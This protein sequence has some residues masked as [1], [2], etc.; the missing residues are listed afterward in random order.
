MYQTKL[1]GRNPAQAAVSFV[2]TS[3]TL[4]QTTYYLIG[5]STS[6]ISNTIGN[7]VTTNGNK[8]IVCKFNKLRPFAINYNTL[9]NQKQY[10][11]YIDECGQNIADMPGTQQVQYNTINMQATGAPS[12]LAPKIGIYHTDITANYNGRLQYNNNN[13]KTADIGILLNG[14]KLALAN[15]NI[16]QLPNPYKIQPTDRPRVDGIQATACSNLTI[17]YNTITKPTAY[18]NG[19]I[20]GT[21]NPCISAGISLFNTPNSRL[22]CNTTNFMS[23]GIELNATTTLTAMQGNIFNTNDVG[24]IR[25]NNSF[26]GNQGSTTFCNANQWTP[27][28]AYSVSKPETYTVS[29]T[30]LTGYTSIFAPIGSGV[31]KPVNNL[32]SSSAFSE[33][34]S[35]NSSNNYYTCSGSSGGGGGSS[36]IVFDG[37]GYIPYAEAVAKGLVEYPTWEES[38]KYYDQLHLMENIRENSD[39]LLNENIDSFYD[40]NMNEDIYKSLEFENELING[41]NIEAQIKLD[42]LEATDNIT[43][44][45][46]VVNQIYLESYLQEIDTFTIE[47]YEQLYDI[48]HSCP[49][50]YGNAVFQ[51]RGMIALLDTTNINDSLLCGNAYAYKSSSPSKITLTSKNVNNPE[52]K[53]LPN[54]AKQD[55]AMEWSGI[56]EC[57]NCKIIIVNLFGETIA[58]L[59]I[60][61][62]QGKINY[63][64]QKLSSGLY[65]C[66]MINN[67][68]T[69]VSKKLI[70][71][72]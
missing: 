28:G 34:N 45:Y 24:I 59:P 15:S 48:A 50:E 31:F 13:I 51:A 69:L 6:R 11:I 58:T 56:T 17:Q 52:L 33:F 60:E 7:T 46:K 22:H 37:T 12:G 23:R 9:N 3:P 10:G 14:V 4:N 5:I 66:H 16:I 44:A 71:Q 27:A 18:G 8:G 29:C 61:I 72:H 62:K 35:P 1:S 55:V 40:A 26:P 32:W 30:P 47:Q 65:Y 49:F 21:G 53:L 42:G 25:M 20:S 2:S 63:N 70:V 64:L 57:I 68:N 67:D 41:N 43:Y 36:P 54:P 38:A 19:C 39:L